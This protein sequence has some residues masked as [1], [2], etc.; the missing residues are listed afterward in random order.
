MP[1]SW[2]LL[3]CYIP[4]QLSLSNLLADLLILGL[5]ALKSLGTETGR[6]HLS[7]EHSCEDRLTGQKW[8]LPRETGLGW[9]F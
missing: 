5:C 1:A 4:L 3:V 6:D 8:S 9:S 2:E 7:E